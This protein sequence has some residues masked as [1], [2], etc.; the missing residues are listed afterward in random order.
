MPLTPRNSTDSVQQHGNIDHHHHHHYDESDFV[1]GTAGYNNV[2]MDP[3]KIIFKK[4]KNNQV[5]LK[6]RRKTRHIGQIAS[7]T[8]AQM[9]HEMTEE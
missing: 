1:E 6:L 7:M 5:E 9:T 4:V 8:A 2:Q 3:S